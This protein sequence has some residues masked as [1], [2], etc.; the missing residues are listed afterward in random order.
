MGLANTGMTETARTMG[1][2]AL[3]MLAFGKRKRLLTREFFGQGIGLLYADWP[4]ELPELEERSKTVSLD[5]MRNISSS[6]P[7]SRPV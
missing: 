6:F 7:F 4:G 2:R 1:K 5:H 3:S